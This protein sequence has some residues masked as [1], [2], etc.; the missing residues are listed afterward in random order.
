MKNT[1]KPAR[2]VTAFIAIGLVSMPIIA[3]AT[4]QNANSSHAMAVAYPWVFKNG[5]ITSKTM[6]LTCAEE[7][8][9]KGNFA[10]VPRDK[11]KSVW[12]S[13]HLAQPS[14]GHLPTR[15]SLRAYG[16][17]LHVAKVIYGSVSWHTRSIWV[18]AGPKTISTAT[19]N[20]YVF[21]VRSN[22]VSYQRHGITGRS[23]EKSNGYKIAAAVLLTPLVTGVSGGPSTPQ[24]Q[25]AVQIAMGNAFNSWV[26]PKVSLR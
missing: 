25:R 17:A 18:V 23:D 6:A 16:R 26:N 15:S 9:N 12:R 1:S 4:R 8:A 24:E 13:L 5:N 10:T 3:S 21:D 14:Y 19:V 11:A 7:I 2:L 20:A 22:S